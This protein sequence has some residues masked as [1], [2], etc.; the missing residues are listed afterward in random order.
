MMIVDL[1]VYPDRVLDDPG[2]L[3]RLLWEVGI[4]EEFL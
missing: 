2:A 4:L 3:R 1:G